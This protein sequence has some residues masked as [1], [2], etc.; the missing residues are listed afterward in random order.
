MIGAKPPAYRIRNRSRGSPTERM[1][2]ANPAAERCQEPER[3]R[4]VAQREDRVGRPRP[5]H[6][7]GEHL[8]EATTPGELRER[9]EIAV[10]GPEAD[11]D[12]VA[13]DRRSPPEEQIGPD[14]RQ[15][16]AG[17]DREA[18]RAVDARV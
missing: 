17:V 3:G 15:V 13:V 9:Q 11:A 10:L 2:F 1:L 16:G 5:R 6:E 4:R 12:R 7:T 18:D 14:R 8:A